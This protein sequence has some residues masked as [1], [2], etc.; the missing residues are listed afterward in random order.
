MKKKSLFNAELSRLVS[1]GRIVLS[2]DGKM[3]TYVKGKK[4]ERDEASCPEQEEPKRRSDKS[5]SDEPT[6]KEYPT[7]E[8]PIG[9]VSILLFYAYAVPQMTRSEQ[10]DAIA[11]CYNVLSSNGLTGRL[12]VAREGFNSTLTGSRASTRIF[13]SALRE[14]FPHVFGSVDF[15]YVDGLPENQALK[16]LKVWPVTE[17]VTYGFDPADAPLKLGGV[18]LKPH[19]FH[20]AMEDPNA[21]I[22]DVRNVN[23][24]AIGKFAPPGDKVLDPMMRRST[25]FPEWIEKNREKLE[26]KKILMYCTA[27]VRCER[28]SA[29]IKK[30][31]F[32]D[33]YQL[34]GGVH[35]YLDAFPEDGGYWIGKNYTFDKRFSH[36][37]ERSE[38]ISNCI[39]CAEP[40]ERYQAQKKCPVCKTEVLVCR[41][42][43]RS[44]PAPPSI[45]L[46][47][48]LC[49]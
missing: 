1:I 36:G 40:W 6:V 15:K 28:A 21:V 19:E 24:T 41:T 3:C 31:G 5:T 2:K 25:E 48:D 30:K 45:K 12:R 34:D 46:K 43:E 14:K 49:K 7:L 26:G 4:R 33:V 47:C 9:D 23:E 13:T 27:G 32:E 39:V 20:K 8:K 38:V 22:I 42:C 18:H 35:R 16:G 44:K 37:A 17:I 10:D 11:F 29:F